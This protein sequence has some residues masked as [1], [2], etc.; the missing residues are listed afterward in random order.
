MRARLAQARRHGAFRFYARTW[1]DERVF[2]RR[3]RRGACAQM[4]RCVVMALM[5]CTFYSRQKT[6]AAENV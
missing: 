2:M 5:R 3:S 4:A 6:D 1:G